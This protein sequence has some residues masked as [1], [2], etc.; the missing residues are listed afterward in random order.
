VWTK[1]EQCLEDSSSHCLFHVECFGGWG[2]GEPNE[3][4]A[5][6]G[7]Q[8]GDGREKTRRG[9]AST[10]G[11]G[12]TS[13]LCTGFTLRG[14][15]GWSGVAMGYP[16]VFIVA[17]VHTAFDSDWLKMI[18]EKRGDETQISTEF[19]HLSL[20]YLFISLFF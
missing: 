1:I 9:R 3:A 15:G 10:G 14:G 8:G 5:G 17:V 11:E 18:M 13:A 19:P 16:L 4:Q 2:K 7:Q 6:G 20:V 12:P